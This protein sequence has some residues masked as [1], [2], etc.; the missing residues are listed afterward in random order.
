MTA[1]AMQMNS[2][3]KVTVEINT[4]SNQENL[5]VR[6]DSKLLNFSFPYMYWQEFEGMLNIYKST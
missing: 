4:W 3:P 5:A 2:G 6:V 1:V